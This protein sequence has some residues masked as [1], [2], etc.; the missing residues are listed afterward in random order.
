[1]PLSSSQISCDHRGQCA[2]GLI[3]RID[4]LHKQG[5]IHMRHKVSALVHHEA[6]NAACRQATPEQIASALEGL[7]LAQCAPRVD[8]H[9]EAADAYPDEPYEVGF[10]SDASDDYQSRWFSMN[11]IEGGSD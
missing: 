9:K 1:M 10:E 8:A 7:R 3:Q 2:N 11:D 6:A 4:A 5:H